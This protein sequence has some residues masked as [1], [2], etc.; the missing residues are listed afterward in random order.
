MHY[1]TELG[2]MRQQEMLAE[3]QR[4]RMVREV[5]SARSSEKILSR[6]AVFAYKKALAGV[7][8]TTLVLVGFLG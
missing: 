7:A 1:S 5:K 8:V 2:R 6:P 3:A 4:Y